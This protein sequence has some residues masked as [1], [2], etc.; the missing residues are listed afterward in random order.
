M[1]HYNKVLTQC[2]NTSNLAKVIVPIVYFNLYRANAIY[3]L[4][5]LHK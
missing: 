1:E 4:P 3:L 2:I 5:A